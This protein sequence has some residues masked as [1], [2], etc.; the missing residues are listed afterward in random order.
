MLSLREPL[1]IRSNVRDYP[2]L[3]RLLSE[4]QFN[5]VGGFASLNQLRTSTLSGSSWSFAINMRESIRAWIG[6]WSKFT[7]QSRVRAHKRRG[8]CE[9]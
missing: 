9:I 3:R 5:G 8:G 1:P 7:P 4:I 6:K 2:Q